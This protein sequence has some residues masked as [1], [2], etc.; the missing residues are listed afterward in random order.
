MQCCLTPRSSGAPT[1]GHQARSGGTRYILASPGLAPCRCRPLSSNVRHRNQ[2]ICLPS[3]PRA[4]NGLCSR[5]LLRTPVKDDESS[6]KTLISG[7]ESV[8]VRVRRVC[9]LHW[10][11][12]HCLKIFR[13][14]H[15]LPTESKGVFSCMRPIL[16]WRYLVWLRLAQFSRNVVILAPSG[17]T[18]C[19]H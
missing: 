9:A 11:D 5:S 10:T 3:R 7:C 16:V 18:R 1:A 13:S 6:F 8:H 17:P 14:H 19:E 4:I 2:P 15:L 12:L